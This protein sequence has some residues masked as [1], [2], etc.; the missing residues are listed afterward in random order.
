MKTIAMSLTLA[1]V[2]AGSYFLIS[3]AES[4][5]EKPGT[6]LSWKTLDEGI[7]SAKQSN[8]KI[9]IDVYTDWCSWCKKMD[10][11]VY[12]DPAVIRALNANFVVV[13]LN[14]ESNNKV[15]F[16]NEV[17]TETQFSRSA[18]VTGFPT[19]LFLDKNATP[20]SALPGFVS[21]D[22]FVKILKF[23]GEDHYKTTTF[24]DY[25]SRSPSATQ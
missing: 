21:A 19:T 11:D 1:F 20:I 7:A 23:I 14:A 6:A 16:N 18:G 17:L 5:P 12:T 4:N 8:K 10:K 13:K 15:T 22:K 25:I 9:L 24:Q 3:P 2:V